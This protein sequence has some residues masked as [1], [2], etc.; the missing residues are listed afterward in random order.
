MCVQEL[1]LQVVVSC[2]MWVQGIEPGPLEEQPVFL[3]S[4]PSQ[5][6]PKY[7]LF[8]FFHFLLGI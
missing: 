8:F 5:R 4:E 2:L 1:E 7:L 6:L 3:I